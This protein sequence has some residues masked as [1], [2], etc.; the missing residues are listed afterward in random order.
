MK[1]QYK[2]MLFTSLF[3]ALMVALL[4]A[5]SVK[6]IREQGDVRLQAYRAEALA[7]V[8]LHLKDLV[9]VAYETIDSSYNNLA[10]VNYLSKYYERRLNSIID[11]G[12]GIV[13][14]YKALADQGRLSLDVA[15]RRALAEIKAL[16]FDAGTGYIWVNDVGDPY[17][18]MLMHPTVPAL[19]GKLL[20]SHRY[21]NA[22]GIGKNLFQAFVDVTKDS[23]EGYV[24]YLWPKPTA[25][26]VTEVQVPKL[27]YVRRFQPWGWILGT[28][29]YIDDA[30]LDIERHIKQS[31]KHMRYANGTGYFWINDN[32][33]PFPSM[34]M[35]P[36]VPALDGK[37]LDSA[38]Y[39]NA[40][41]IGKNLFQAFAEVTAAADDGSGFV[42]YLWPKPTPS[43]LTPDVPKMSYVRLHK[44]TGW[45]IGTGVYIDNIDAAVREKQAAIE[46]E[47]TALIRQNV[48]ASVS[49]L[50]VALVLSHFFS[51]GLTRPIR[52]LTAVAEEISKGRNLEA[53][54]AEADRRDEIGDLA[55]SIDRLK[56]SVTIMMNRMKKA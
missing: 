18:R 32:A 37:R 56:K 46:A 9:D 50:L 22:Q 55:R 44:A 15:Q 1:I 33:L 17:P 24:D 8:K 21:N 13:N 48:W 12:Y 49:F 43:G 27:S 31:I 41:G 26:G 5:V 30:R 36:T 38:E 3:L 40:L 4:T 11:S 54:I 52:K 42:D 34:I 23:G 16:R 35:H 29:I 19:D 2:L 20:N 53:P 51:A 14:R 7:D 47:A 28:G 25:D 45:I 6:A 39:D 10:D